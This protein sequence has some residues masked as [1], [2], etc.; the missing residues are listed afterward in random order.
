MDAA[1]QMGGVGPVVRPR[2][3]ADI[4]LDA[5]QALRLDDRADIVEH[6]AGDGRRPRDAHQHADDAAARGADDDGARNAERRHAVEHVVH[7]GERVVACRARGPLRASAAAIVEGDH[8]ARPVAMGREVDGELVEIAA[9]A[10]EARQAHH[11]QPGREPIAVVARRQPQAVGTRVDGFA[12]D[13]APTVPRSSSAAS[14]GGF[15]AGL[16]RPLGDISRRPGG[17]NRGQR[18]P[19]DL[20]RLRSASMTSAGSP[21]RA[22]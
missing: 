19:A 3:A 7:L 22:R 2:R 17:V 21:R 9:V 4:G 14:G 6:Q 5:R 12:E 15:G 10:G 11:R 16:A 1:E 8:A 18:Q 20:P 13:R